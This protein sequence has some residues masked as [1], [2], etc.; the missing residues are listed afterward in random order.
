M[1]YRLITRWEITEEV[2]EQYF[3]TSGDAK[4]ITDYLDIAIKNGAAVCWTL[5]KKQEDG[6]IINLNSCGYVGKQWE[7]VGWLIE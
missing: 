4:T 5:Q 7:N 3:S 1:N 6:Q 2:K